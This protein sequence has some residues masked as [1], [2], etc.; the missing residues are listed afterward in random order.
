MRTVRVR[1]T[2]FNAARI[3]SVKGLVQS[4]TQVVSI[5]DITTVDWHWAQRAKKA[6]RRN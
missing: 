4:G 2:G 6:K 3:A 5:Q 1:I